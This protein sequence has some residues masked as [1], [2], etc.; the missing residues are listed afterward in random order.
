MAVL[1]HE[2]HAYCISTPVCAELHANQLSVPVLHSIFNII[3]KYRLNLSVI[4]D[5]TESFHIP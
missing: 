5:Y 1:C 4:R 2:K 3:Q